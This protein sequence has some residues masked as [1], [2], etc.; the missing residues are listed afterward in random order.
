MAECDLLSDTLDAQNLRVLQ[1]YADRAAAA[2]AA[3]PDHNGWLNRVQTCG[4]LTAAQLT[5]VHGSLIAR[6]MLR[7][8]LVSRTAGLQ[9]RISDLGREI[10]RRQN[11]VLPEPNAS[12]DPSDND[13][14]AP[15]E[16]HG[17]E[18]HSADPQMARAA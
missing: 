11:T 17:S 13:R 10:L 3:D 15:A 18:T 1:A 14:A 2:R 7:F 12:D 16:A 6:G 9:Y 8:E 5:A 4:E